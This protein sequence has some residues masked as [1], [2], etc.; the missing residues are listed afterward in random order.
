V[1]KGLKAPGFK[2]LL[3]NSQ[4]LPPTSRRMQKRAAQQQQQQVEEQH[5]ETIANLGAGTIDHGFDG[6]GSAR[7]MAAAVKLTH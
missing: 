4:L 3:T 2:P 1:K 6:F 5:M 7:G